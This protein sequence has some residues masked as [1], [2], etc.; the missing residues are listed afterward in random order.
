MVPRLFLVSLILFCLELGVFL[1][2]LPWTSLWERNYFLFRYP[3]LTPWLLNHYLRG[4]LSGL[5][6]VDIG[7]GAWYAAHFRQTLARLLPALTPGAGA[8]GAPP[9]RNHGATAR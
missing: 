9:S 7:L 5:G 4:A 6:L 8:A 3:G 1:V 2:I